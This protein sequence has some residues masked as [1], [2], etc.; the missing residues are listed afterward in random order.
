MK[1]GQTFLGKE[2]TMNRKEKNI[3][4][5]V[6]R[7]LTD[8]EIMDEF[9]GCHIDY[10]E[11]KVSEV[12]LMSLGSNKLKEDINGN[13]TYRHTFT[14]FAEKHGYDDYQRMMG[15]SWLLKLTYYLNRIKNVEIIAEIDNTAKKGML[16]SLS[17]S[18]GM[19]FEIPTGDINDG[20]TYQLQ[21]YADYVIKEEN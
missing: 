8:T 11:N 5:T 20:I 21:I 14:L 2:L 13:V 12:G 16:L 9:N 7:L 4:E 15:S 18:N 19:F 3:I 1:V 17:C 6:K 10:T